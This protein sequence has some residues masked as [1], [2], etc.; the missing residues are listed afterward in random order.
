MSESRYRNGARRRS[1]RA[2]VRSLGLPC[3]ICGQPIDYDLPAGDPMS[4]EL[5][6]I[7]PVSLGGSP[8]DP[9]NVQPAHR[10]CNQK[11]GNKIWYRLGG[12]EEGRKG[13]FGSDDW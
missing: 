3:A 11:K 5:D 8:I 10:L 4:Y 9:G 13:V 1:L 12:G 6:E 2:R 7:V